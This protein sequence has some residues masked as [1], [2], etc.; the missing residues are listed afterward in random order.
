[1]CRRTRIDYDTCFYYNK[2]ERCVLFLTLLRFLPV[3]TCL[4]FRQV[5]KAAPLEGAG[6]C[7]FPPY[8][9]E[10]R[11]STAR[12]ASDGVCPDGDI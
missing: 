10:L 3:T 11:P 7:S 5:T 2:D 12:C 6:L 1:M 9:K 4:R 8:S